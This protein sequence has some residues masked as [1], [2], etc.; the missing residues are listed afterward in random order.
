MNR[1][2]FIT[3]LSGILL[4]SVAPAIIT[5]PGLL[6]PVRR[7]IGTD[8]GQ[9]IPYIRGTVRIPISNVG[10][11]VGSALGGMLIGEYREG[12]T[13]PQRIWQNGKLISDTIYEQRTQF[14]KVL[15]SYRTT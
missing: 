8:Y 3:G 13:H 6:M 7:R 14:G 9:P 5:T 4:A 10:W 15:N 12:E 1:R 11:W 2:R